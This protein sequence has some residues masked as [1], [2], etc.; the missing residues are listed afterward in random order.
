MEQI[1]QLNDVFAGMN[2]FEDLALGVVASYLANHL[3]IITQNKG[4]QT[5][6]DE[7]YQRALEQWCRN[8]DVRRSLSS[9]M[10]AHVDKLK[11]A[12]KNNSLPI[13]HPQLV[14]LEEL[15]AA[16]LR[17]DSLCYQ[18]ILESRLIYQQELIEEVRNA[19]RDLKSQK[20]DTFAKIRCGQQNHLPVVGYLRRYCT[21]NKDEHNRLYNSLLNKKPN[22]LADYVIGCVLPNTNKFVLYSSAQTGKTTELQNLCYELQESGLYYPV[23]FEVRNN[24][25]LKRFDLP[26]IAEIDGK[27]VVVVI[28]ALDE[29]NGQKRE[30]LLE[31][32]CAYAAAHPEMKMV[33]SCRSNYRREDR[34]DLFQEVYLENL[35]HNE[36]I[37]YIDSKLGRGSD[38]LAQIN[39]R[40]LYDFAKNPFYLQVIVSSYKEKGNLP[41]N[42]AEI[43]E[44][45]IKKSYKNQKTK[46][47]SSTKTFTEEQM[48]AQLERVA[49]VQSL[50]NVQT[51]SHEE[52]RQCAI[53]GE[54][55]L[56]ECKRY[57]ILQFDGERWF[58]IHSAFRE[59]LVA[60]YLKNK[61]LYAAKRLSM[62]PNQRIKP[63]WYNIIMVWLSMYGAEDKKKIDEIVEWLQR[64][65]SE[66][67]AYIDK[68]NIDRQTRSGIFKL[69][70][71]E[72]KDLGIRFSNAMS[73]DYRNLIDFAYSQETM[74]FLIQEI[75]EAEVDSYYHAD[76]MC[77]CYFLDWRLLNEDLRN[78]LLIAL[79]N[80]IKRALS[81]CSKMDMN[82]LFLGNPYFRKEV[83]VD[84]YYNLLK[85]SDN[86]DA[87]KELIGLIASVHCSDKYADYILQK[88]KLVNDYWDNGV[89]VLVVRNCV[90]DAYRGFSSVEN[91]KKLFSHLCEDQYLY[92]NKDWKN[93]LDVIGVLLPKAYELGDTN[94]H[95]AL[96][97]FYCFLFRENNNN[98]YAED[99]SSILPIWREIYAKYELDKPLRESFLN[100]WKQLS[101][102]KNG[103][104]GDITNLILKTGLWMTVEDVDN[105]YNSFS[106]DDQNLASWINS[107]CPCQEVVLYA[108]KRYDEFFPEHPTL[109]KARVRKAQHLRD[110]ANYDIF[111]Q[112][113]LEAIEKFPTNNRQ[114]I[115]R[116]YRKD[117]DGCNEYVL[118]FFSQL[119]DNEGFFLV[120]EIKDKIRD[121]QIY[122][123]FFMHE[124]ANKVLNG[125]SKDFI[126]QEIRER[127]INKARYII[128]NNSDSRFEYF[129]SVAI[130]LMLAGVFSIDRDMLVSLLR[131]S[132]VSITKRQKG[133]FGNTYTLFE[134]I[135][136]NGDSAKIGE[137]VL[138]CFES[139]NDIFRRNCV[140]FSKFLLDKHIKGGVDAIFKCVADKTDRWQ[141]LADELI[142]HHQKINELKLLAENFNDEDLLSICHS[143]NRQ[144]G[145]EPW[146]LSQ[147]EPRFD[148]L[149]NNSEIDTL[150]F[151]L[152][153]GSL[154]ALDYLVDNEDLLQKDYSFS[155]QY[156]STV[157]IVPLCELL[158]KL[159]LDRIAHS[160][161]VQSIT[162]SL[163]NIVLKNEDS[164]DE[165]IKGLR[166]IIEKD[167]SFSYL[168]RTIAS[169]EEKYY[170]AF[171]G[172][173]DISK[174]IEI[175]DDST[176]LNRE[177]RKVFMD[178]YV[179]I[180]YNWE[181]K[182]S[183]TVDYL[184]LV[185]ETDSIPYKRDT[186]DCPYQDNIK[187]FMEAI[188]E[189]KKVIVVLSRAYLMSQNCMFE[190]IGIVEN[191]A[192][193][194]NL[195]PIVEDDTIRDSRFYVDLVRHWKEEKERQKQIVD[196]INEID[197]NQAIP[198]QKKYDQ[199]EKIY[200]LLT[201]IKDY[202]DWTN[203]SSMSSLSSTRFKVI[204]DKILEDKGE[205]V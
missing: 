56:E 38:L 185:L 175:I 148:Q 17:N 48:F 87:V 164:K 117:P 120:E 113:V 172:Y 168:N 190:L 141:Y 143:F 184:C 196:E 28:D 70:L 23:S 5:R 116:E 3:P 146:I 114:E 31:E 195:Y 121:K 125:Q 92:L 178:G 97:G 12:L 153:A 61:G 20:E 127:I 149:I 115:Y 140:A 10:F 193:P 54:E 63:E 51:L 167:R 60:N 85:D 150:R 201:T 39:S 46:K 203:T 144:Q 180:S 43:Y 42:R 104:C 122:E 53:G 79:D 7:A 130:K 80:S 188:R 107:F 176:D 64:S 15:W 22:T 16:E 62:H 35:H 204:I 78:R 108:R 179:Y 25:N 160:M 171:S 71:C 101:S 128:N 96:D 106:Q 4:L 156:S 151:L 142:Q 165:V 74:E 84:R 198:E 95:Q 93:Y 105:L 189:G 68:E 72:Y 162:S 86:R 90:Y 132:S 50:M 147:L 102:N 13:G 173:K 123:A 205:N 183:Q 177:E 9:R 49:L 161:L 41:D 36:I 47:T 55:L 59:W 73:D 1:L 75:A 30:D 19:I 199:I 94:M 52:M 200:S 21:T 129:Q 32:V 76:L 24:T 29:V 145:L 82:L 98:S 155:L 44:F 131:Y 69:I 169:I 110:F 11:L 26:E 181:A 2:V 34:F 154:K 135:C 99:L 139:Q 6:M 159:K 166:K 186:R 157:A 133:N 187:Q 83:F 138:N 109:A 118:S 66:L 137:A 33:L 37:G 45:F 170:A 126:T 91:I 163:Q 197:M 152:S 158:P 27:I 182:S 8:D 124:V 111:K 136:E 192:Y 119:C 112:Y 89:S 18:F 103:N 77:F 81:V 88:E 65:C 100:D 14:E 194:A 57:D 174:V 202:I 40:N 191:A 58:F 134:F 67:I